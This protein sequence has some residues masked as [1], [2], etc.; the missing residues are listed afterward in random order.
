M[1]ENT[2]QYRTSNNQGQLSKSIQNNQDYRI[3]INLKQNNYP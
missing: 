3:Q 1:T 2:N